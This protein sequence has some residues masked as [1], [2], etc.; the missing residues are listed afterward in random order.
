MAYQTIYPYTGE[1]LHEFPNASDEKLEETLTVAHRLYQQWRREKLATR[2]PVLHRLATLLREKRTEM[3][4]IMTQDMGKLLTEAAGEVDL[5]ADIADYYADHGE[6][7]LPRWFKGHY[8][9]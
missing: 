2:K 3:A 8:P 6:G 9:R 4:R 7:K 1:V 5:C